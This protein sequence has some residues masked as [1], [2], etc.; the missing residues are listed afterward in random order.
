MSVV[1]HCHIVCLLSDQGSSS[2]V[3]HPITTSTT[4]TNTGAAEG[5]NNYLCLIS[6]TR[7]TLHTYIHKC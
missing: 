5:G 7:N 4:T 6:D 1:S 2:T 3:D